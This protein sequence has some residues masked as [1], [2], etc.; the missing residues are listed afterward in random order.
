MLLVLYFHSVVS[1]ASMTCSPACQN[2][3]TCYRS[4]SHSHSY[5]DC[6]SGYNG[7][8]CQNEGVY[9]HTTSMQ[10]AIDPQ[11]IQCDS[12]WSAVCTPGCQ[13]GGKCYSTFSY[14]YCTCPRGYSGS[15]CQNRG[16]ATYVHIPRNTHAAVDPYYKTYVHK[17]RHDDGR[18]LFG[19][20][21]DNPI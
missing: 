15:Y 8:Y 16:I 21:P 17:W 12:H 11:I 5:C 20:E 1:V 19:V 18:T 9:I 2:G 4:S 10:E 14:T 7:S 6:P 3:G 13:N